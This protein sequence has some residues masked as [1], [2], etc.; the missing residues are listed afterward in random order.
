MLLKIRQQLLPTK[1]KQPK[2]ANA[3]QKVAGK[4]WRKKNSVPPPVPFALFFNPPVSDTERV[5]GQNYVAKARTPGTF[6]SYIY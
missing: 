4:L 1:L 6:K 5:F 3:A 2:R